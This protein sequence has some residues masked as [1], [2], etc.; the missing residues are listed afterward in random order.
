MGI[1]RTF[2]TLLRENR[3]E[4]LK[5]SLESSPIAMAIQEFVNPSRTEWEGT[6]KQLKSIL[7]KDY[8]QP[9][10]GWPK[11]PK[12]LSEALRRSAPALREIGVG[13]EFHGHKRDGAHVSIWRIFQTE[14]DHHNDHT[15]TS[16]V[17]SEGKSTDCDDVTDV[18]VESEKLNTP[19][20]E[21][22][23]QDGGARVAVE[24]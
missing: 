13:V 19:E 17:N 4:S 10:E 2:T 24:I 12:G 22:P 16:P 3:A 1:N 23:D 20:K 11:S 21:M 7:D 9:G 8:H 18:T 5:R 15:V 14:I 6:V